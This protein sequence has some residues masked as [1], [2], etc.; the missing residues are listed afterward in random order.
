MR[1]GLIG[2]LILA[3]SALAADPTPLIRGK[4]AA[5]DLASAEAILEDYKRESGESAEYWK[6]ASWLARGAQSQGACGDANRW[7]AST[8]AGAEKSLGL[9]KIESDANLETAIGASIEVRAKC[10]VSQG[11]R[12]EAVNLLQTSLDRWKGT[13][14]EKRIRKNHNALT[15]AGQKAPPV[16]GVEPKGAILFFWAHYCGDCKAQAPVVNRAAAKFAGRGLTLIAPTQL[17]GLIGD[18]H[19]VK[20]E[21]ETAFI[22]KTWKETYGGDPGVSHPVD[23]AAMVRY[24][25]STTPTLV[26]VDKRGRVHSYQPTRLTEK[27]LE[28]RIEAALR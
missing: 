22:E 8:L 24:G 25:V 1:S 15:L 3:V 21:D 14:L 12:S 20:P 18:K 4:L 6:A 16:G 26:L 13:A 2:S 28:R 9:R 7:A 19:D 27:E 11:K 10:L 17:Y 5:G 23:E